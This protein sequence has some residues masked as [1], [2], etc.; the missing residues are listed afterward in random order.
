M[1]ISDP[2]MVVCVDGPTRGKLRAVT[3][4]ERTRFHAYDMMAVTTTRVADTTDVVF[5]ALTY[6]VHLISFLGFGIRVASMHLNA[7]DID[8]YDIITSLFNEAG[9]QATYR[10]NGSI[11]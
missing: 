3:G 7:T 1:P 5:D 4:G 9:R 10:V 11:S 6:H 2:V 8:P